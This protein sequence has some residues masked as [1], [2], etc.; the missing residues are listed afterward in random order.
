MSDNDTPVRITAVRPSRTASVHRREMRYLLSMGIRTACFVSA[1]LVSGPLR[2][3]LVIA[4]FI[5]PY[6]AVVMANTA[7]EADR[8]FTAF[9]QDRPLLEGPV[10]EHDPRS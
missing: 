7:G 5:L 10:E 9:E 1:I 2:W 8:A 6:I 3:V 4:A